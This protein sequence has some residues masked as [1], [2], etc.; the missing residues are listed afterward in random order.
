MGGGPQTIS[1]VFQPLPASYSFNIPA[2]M[3]NPDV[4]GNPWS[5][6]R[7]YIDGAAQRDFR[8]QVQP[9]RHTIRLVSG[10]FQ[11]ET[12]VDFEAGRS[13]SFEPFLSLT[14]Q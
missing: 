13:Y 6:V 2:G 4:K 1:P 8:G 3:L 11:I 10:A 12:V 7:L 9:G 14:I 5:Q